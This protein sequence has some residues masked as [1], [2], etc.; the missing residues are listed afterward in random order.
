[1][2]RRIAFALTLVATGA[3]LA[4]GWAVPRLAHWARTAARP[5]PFWWPGEFSVVKIPSSVDD[6]T[7]R[8]YFLPARAGPKMPLLVSLHVW[9]GNYASPDPLALEAQA[10][11]W[12][13]IHP[14]FRG[15]N[16][17]LD[18][19]LSDKVLA[20]IDDAITYASSKGN[21]D[22]QNIFVVGFS[23]GGYA[24]LGSYLKTRHQVR[25]WQAWAPIADLEAWYWQTKARKLTDLAGTILSC[26][27]RESELDAATAKLRSPLYWTL[28]A[29]LSGRMEIYAGSRDGYAGTVPISHAIRF[30]NRIVGSVGEGEQTISTELVNALVTQAQPPT[31]EML[32]DRIVIKRADVGFASLTVFEGGHEILVGPAFAR[33]LSIST[34][35]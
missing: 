30:Y 9:S 32:G 29:A 16:A 15:P 17:T 18:N 1:M 33:L 21:V 3:F 13:Y 34:K 4:G 22:E 7:Q 23:G 26:T 5:E 8:A 19:C 14:D 27:G 11:G 31:T 6:A 24:A 2:T 28:P 10:H 25:L 12:N 20:D 35:P